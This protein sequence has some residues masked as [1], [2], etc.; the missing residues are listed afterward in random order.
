[1]YHFAGEVIVLNVFDDHH[2]RGLLALNF[3]GDKPW[4]VKDLLNHLFG[5]GQ[6]RRGFAMAVK[7]SRDQ[8]FVTKST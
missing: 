3:Q 8:P 6:R 1:M 5:D 7:D 4:M 2:S